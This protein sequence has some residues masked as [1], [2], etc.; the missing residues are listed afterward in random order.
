MR[1]DAR[2]EV[3]LDSGLFCEELAGRQGFEPR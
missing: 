2:P 1:L 3:R